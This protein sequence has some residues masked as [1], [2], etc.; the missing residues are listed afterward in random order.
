MDD[1]LKKIVIMVDFA[2]CVTK[3]YCN[4]SIKEDGGEIEVYYCKAFILYV[5]WHNT[6]SR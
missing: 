6:S 1:W 5:K 3:M 2:T 4:R